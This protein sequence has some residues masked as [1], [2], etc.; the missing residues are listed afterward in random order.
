MPLHENLS[1]GKET[2]G[3][4]TRKELPVTPMNY[5]NILI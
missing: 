3:N 2:K 1:N 5:N 4:T